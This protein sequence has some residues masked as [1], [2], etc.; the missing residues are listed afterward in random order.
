MVNIIE[1]SWH[2]LSKFVSSYIVMQT[3]Y[4]GTF[5]KVHSEIRTTSI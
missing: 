4:S 3:R 1:V 5:D 2:V